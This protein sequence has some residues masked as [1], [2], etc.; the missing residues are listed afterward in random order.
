[1]P[2]RVM[3]ANFVIKFLTW[4]TCGKK[5]EGCTHNY[6]HI[7][8]FTST[9]VYVFVHMC[10]YAHVCVLDFIKLP[11]ASLLLLSLSD[12]IKSVKR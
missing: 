4:S 3:Y 8:T 10:A 11:G 1:M 7:S 2:T 5:I 12:S 6:L 9:Y